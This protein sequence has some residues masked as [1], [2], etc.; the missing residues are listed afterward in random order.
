[1]EF[2]LFDGEEGGYSSVGLLE[3][4][5]L[6]V[7]QDDFSMGWHHVT[8]YSIYLTTGVRFIWTHRANHVANPTQNMPIPLNSVAKTLALLFH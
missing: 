3:I 4:S 1:M 6:L 5:K 7:T 8:Q 2:G